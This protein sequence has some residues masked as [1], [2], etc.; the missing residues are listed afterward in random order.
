MFGWEKFIRLCFGVIRGRCGAQSESPG[1]FFFLSLVIINFFGFFSG[2]DYHK[3]CSTWI[4]RSGVSNFYLFNSV[5][6]FQENFNA[7]DKIKGG[8]V[9]GFVEQQ[10]HAGFEV[11]LYW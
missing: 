2:T 7:V 6:K 10:N 4:K 9:D 1:I 8:P 3:T 5:I 11:A